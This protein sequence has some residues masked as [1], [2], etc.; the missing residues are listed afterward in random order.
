[1]HFELDLEWFPDA[2]GI[3]LALRARGQSDLDWSQNESSR[4]CG[5][6]GF[7][8]H[9]SLGRCPR[10]LMNAAP[11]ALNRYPRQT[12]PSGLEIHDTL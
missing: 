4:A 11:L 12:L 7:A 1:M 6:G 2:G 8:L 9:K 10:L 3:C 5:T